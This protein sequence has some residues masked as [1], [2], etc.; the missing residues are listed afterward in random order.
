MN[1]TTNYNTI[2]NFNTYF[3]IKN[4]QYIFI[5]FWNIINNDAL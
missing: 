1:F 2:T 5:V 3:Q 4:V